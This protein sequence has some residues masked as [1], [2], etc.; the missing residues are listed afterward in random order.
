MPRQTSSRNGSKRQLEKATD[1][2]WK[3]HFVH[4]SCL[5]TSTVA[6]GMP[7]NDLQRPKRLDLQSFSKASETGRWAA[8]IYR[9]ATSKM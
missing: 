8:K 9:F 4:G 2:Q 7:E 5:E 1:K 3:Y 6:I